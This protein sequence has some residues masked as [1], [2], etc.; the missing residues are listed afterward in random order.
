[1]KWYLASAFII[2]PLCLLLFKS[3]KVY[4]NLQMSPQCAKPLSVGCS[5]V[6][7][8]HFSV[9][10][11]TQQSGVLRSDYPVKQGQS[12]RGVSWKKVG[13]CL[14]LPYEL[15]GLKDYLRSLSSTLYRT[16]D[17]D[18]YA[19]TLCTVRNIAFSWDSQSHSSNRVSP[20]STRHEEP[21]NTWQT[22]LET[23]CPLLVLSVFCS[24]LLPCPR[25]T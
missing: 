9:E 11:W 7:I 3:G 10:N 18:W 8:F 12:A 14:S 5:L 6:E 20:F 21:S 15:H 25:I 19:Y 13:L 4:A 2:F 24:H 22:S 16:E 1:M 23:F 17:H